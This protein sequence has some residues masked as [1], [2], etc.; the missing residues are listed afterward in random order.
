MVAAMT[1]SYPSRVSGARGGGGGGLTRKGLIPAWST[2]EMTEQTLTLC[3]TS[4]PPRMHGT[5]KTADHP[6]AKLQL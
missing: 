2:Q 4:C 5:P 1:V 6:S 3:L